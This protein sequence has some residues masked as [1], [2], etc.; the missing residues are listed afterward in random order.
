MSGRDEAY[1]ATVL[2]DKS[3]PTRLT[4]KEMKDGFGSCLNFFLAYGLRP[5]SPEDC[6]EALAISRAIKEGRA[7]DAA[8]AS[9]GK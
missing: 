2:L 1:A 5:W 3:D 7:D 9:G 8:Q 4:H 6:E